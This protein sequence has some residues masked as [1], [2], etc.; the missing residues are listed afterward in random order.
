VNAERFR[1]LAEAWGGDLDRWPAA[2]R[3]QARAF[4]AVSPDAAQA[5]AEARGL[6]AA[7]DAWRPP[8]A[9][10]ALRERIIA[11]APAPRRRSPWVWAS[12]W[13]RGAGLAAACAA[14]VMAGA[15]LSGRAAPDP[16]GEAL[17][18]VATVFQGAPSPGVGLE[19][20]ES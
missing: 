19:P 1:D 14:G 2:E 8:E 4:L 13:L 6:D 18:A 17:I 9:S 11:S 20:E 7:L 15:A 12:P 10:A 5:L 16:A 3:D